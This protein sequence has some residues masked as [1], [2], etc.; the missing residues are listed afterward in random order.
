MIEKIKWYVVLISVC[1]GV[2]GG[3]FCLDFYRLRN[4][5]DNLNKQIEQKDMLIEFLNKED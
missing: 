5:I 3:V 2:A 4:E 1:I